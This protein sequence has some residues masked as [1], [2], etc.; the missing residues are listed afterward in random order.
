VKKT[1][2][3]M[4]ETAANT[5]GSG[6]V[7]MPADVQVDKEKKKKKER[8]YDGRTREGRKFV[9]RIMARRRLAAETKRETR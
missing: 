9:E 2:K 4:W 1:F 7:S 6:E 3:D 8:L 5:A